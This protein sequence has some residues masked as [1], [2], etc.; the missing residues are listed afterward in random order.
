MMEALTILK[1]LLREKIFRECENITANQGISV[2]YIE[3]IF[4]HRDQLDDD[5]IVGISLVLDGKESDHVQNPLMQ[6]D[7]LGFYDLNVTTVTSILHRSLIKY[8]PGQLSKRV[9]N[10]VI[11]ELSNDIRFCELGNDTIRKD[12]ETFTVRSFGNGFQLYR[13]SYLSERKDK[14]FENAFR[15]TSEYVCSFVD[16]ESD[17]FI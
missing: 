17:L 13:K 16:Y 15:S 8:I 10:G 7:V 14:N 2:K 6:L 1:I 11:I 3:S 9:D 12:C 5:I 4:D